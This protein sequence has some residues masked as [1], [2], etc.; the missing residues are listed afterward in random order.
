MVIIT[1]SEC[2]SVGARGMRAWEWHRTFQGPYEFAPEDGW[3]EQKTDCTFNNFDKLECIG[4]S[5]TC[6]PSQ[7]EIDKNNPDSISYTP[8]DP[9]TIPRDVSGMTSEEQSAY[10]G[11]L[12][13]FDDPDDYDYYDYSDD[14]DYCNYYDFLWFLIFYSQSSYDFL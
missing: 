8:P 1:K 14:H 7:D 5:W 9:S 11:N 6:Q 4:R 10:F 3:Y 12:D 13:N 2:E